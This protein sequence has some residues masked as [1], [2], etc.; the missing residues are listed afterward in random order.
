[1][2]DDAG[3]AVALTIR[4]HLLN[5]A[6]LVSYAG[7]GFPRTLNSAQFP[8][9]LPGGP[10]DAVIDVFLA[11]PQIATHADNTLTIALE[12][13]GPLSVTMNGV[14]EVGQIDGFLTIRIRP[15]FVILGTNLVLNPTADDV[16]VTEWDFTL[17]PPSSFSSGADAYLRS[18]VFRDRLQTAIR[19]AIAIGVVSLPKIDISFLGSLATAVEMTAASLV[20]HGAV[21]VGLS[22]ESQDL[23]LVGNVDLLAD[24]AG[25]NDLAA[26]INTAAIPVFLQ[27]VQNEVND[28]VSKMGATLPQPVAITSGTGKFLV[29]GSA[30]TGSGSA[31]R[32]KRKRIW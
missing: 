11:P 9:G 20:R 24:F 29:S 16:T 4:E 12:M 27:V 18:T 22:I 28:E 15:E 3:F 10:P 2:A 7:N 6:L 17:I 19:Q 25:E 13:W 5:D 31:T 30:T 8:G 23:T 21:M 14:N 1:M 26:V 32:R